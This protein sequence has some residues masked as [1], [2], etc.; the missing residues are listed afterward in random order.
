MT[1]EKTITTDEADRVLRAD[2]F[3]AVRSIAEEAEQMVRDGDLADEEALTEWIEQSV[4]GCHWVI[5]TY[6]NFQVLRYCSNHDAYTEYGDVPTDCDGSIRWAAMAYAA[7]LEDVR[8]AV[9]AWDDMQPEEAEEDEDD[10][11]D[12]AG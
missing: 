6:A 8:D 4:D 9:P 5:Y 7:M 12:E 1:E 2:Y 11:E 10:T 3:G